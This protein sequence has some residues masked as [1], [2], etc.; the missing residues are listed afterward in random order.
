MALLSSAERTDV[1]R[2]YHVK[3]AKLSLGSALLKRL[4]IAQCCCCSRANDN[5]NSD[6]VSW[7]SATAVR[8]E[9]TKPVF[10]HPP[11]SGVQPLLFNVS[12]QAGLVVLFAVEGA[13]AGTQIGVD[14]VCPS[15]RRSRDLENIQ[16]EGWA[17][18][19]DVHSSVFSPGETERLKNLP[20]SSS[21]ATTTT[22]SST[23]SMIQGG[24]FV[25]ADKLLAYFYALWCLREA[26]I[27]MTGDALLASWLQ[28]LDMRHFAPPG[29]TSPDDE[30]AS[31]LRISFGVYPVT[32]VDMR[33][34]WFLGREYMIATA[35]RRAGKNVPAEFEVGEFEVLEM[36]HVLAMAEDLQTREDVTA[37]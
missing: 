37:L 20:F 4:V 28:E 29:E 16:N 6:P 5:D 9:R 8:D 18:Y 1:L 22:S 27:K 30:A 21:A 26:Y 15:E 19:V 14:V 32:D 17:Q 12:H 2:Y 23:S 36:E 10:Y 7:A 13:A 11:G 25:P 33:L 24:P 34:E 3:D 31:G 35:V